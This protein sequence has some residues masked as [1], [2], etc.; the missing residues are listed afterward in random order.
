M[1]DSKKVSKNN[2]KPKPRQKS[3]SPAATSEPTATPENAAADL[4]ASTTA[5]IKPKFEMMSIDL[6]KHS[7]KKSVQYN[8]ISSVAKKL[9]DRLSKAAKRL[10]DPTIS[11]PPTPPPSSCCSDKSESDMPQ[12]EVT[13]NTML[14]ESDWSNTKPISLRNLQLLKQYLIFVSK[15]ST[16]ISFKD[17]SIQLSLSNA[18]ESMEPSTESAKSAR[19]GATLIESY[20]HEASNM[21]K[22]LHLSRTEDGRSQS[23][24]TSRI[25]RKRPGR[26]PKSQLTHELAHE[27]KSESGQR[28]RMKRKS[29]HRHSSAG[30][31][32][33][34]ILSAHHHLK[35]KNIQCIC[36]SPHEEIESMVQCDDCYRYLHLECLELNDA[37]LTET[38]RC[39]SCFLSLGSCTGKN[40]KLLSAITWRY[41]AQW[42]SQRLALKSQDAAN[43]DDEDAEEYDD[44]D[45]SSAMEIDSSPLSRFNFTA[46]NAANS[47][48]HST[49][50]KA[51]V[52]SS[53]TPPPLHLHDDDDGYSTDLPGPETP[54]DWPDVSSES[55]FS[56][57]DSTASEV[58]TPSESLSLDP[59]D[60][61]EDGQL[62]LD[63]ESLEILSRLAYLQ[64]L[65]SVKKELFAPN[66][67]DVFLCENS[68]NNSNVTVAS[69][70]AP[71][72]A[73][74]VPPSDICSQDLSEFSF[75][76][77]PFWEPLF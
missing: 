54:T 5:N 11:L 51:S 32:T 43:T 67:S 14:S 23:R 10:S 35:K 25:D 28:I 57:Q 9:K 31:S 16:E 60:A 1:A 37:A 3:K 50:D 40:A 2:A 12:Q 22:E 34:S 36:S 69:P 47:S 27:D 64:S 77:G 39:P 20:V 13:A 7:L 56:S 42:K 38:F 21:D 41:A 59:F 55:R 48:S 76:S 71:R 6:K 19:C 58:T 45:F 49:S 72:F 44:D 65:D 66:A 62:V 26:P 17:H 4:A 75:D 52:S 70:Q 18:D 74:N 68:S 53:T 24:S 29:I 61:K 15:E 30:H 73:A 8:D 33:N 63:P 46:A